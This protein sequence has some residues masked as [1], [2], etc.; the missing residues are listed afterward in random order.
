MDYNI[1]IICLTIII[2]TT[3]IFILIKNS[4]SFQL[5]G[6]LQKKK[7]SVK[8]NDIV[9]YSELPTINLKTKINDIDS[10]NEEQIINYYKSF[11]PSNEVATLEVY[12]EYTRIVNEC[13]LRILPEI[14]LF[15][16]K[17]NITHLKD[18]EYIKYVEEKISYFCSIYDDAFSKSF[19]NFIHSLKLK[20]VLGVYYYTF[21]YCIRNFYLLILAEHKS[22]ESDRKN[23]FKELSDLK[24]NKQLINSKQVIE[25]LYKM[26]YDNIYKDNQLL[27]KIIIDYNNLLLG[28][29][30]DKVKNSLNIYNNKD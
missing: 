27:M 22:N 7:I 29:F 2:I 12:K 5:E 20:E 15:L 25:T 28:I 16:Y 17:N 8:A 24:K 4:K 10:Y 26:M 1:P 23:Y 6:D 30:H 18:N 19:N 11:K 21:D 13:N 9:N 3:F 14:A